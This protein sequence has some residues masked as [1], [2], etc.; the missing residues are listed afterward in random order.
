MK[1]RSLPDQPSD[2]EPFKVTLPHG[3]S[4]NYTKDYNV[5]PVFTFRSFLAS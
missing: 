4:Y 5:M 3:I 1:G 2:C